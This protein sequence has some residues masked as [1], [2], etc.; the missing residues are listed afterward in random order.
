[1]MRPTR[2][3]A[4]HADVRAEM[5]LDARARA[6]GPHRSGA[7]GTPA[8]RF[9]RN[10]RFA[11]A[12]LLALAGRCTAAGL[13]C[14]STSAALA[15]LGACASGADE[16]CCAAL[17]GWNDA[18]CFCPGVESA[19]SQ[20]ETYAAQADALAAACSVAKAD[21]ATHATCASLSA[22]D[23]PADEMPTR[24]LPEPA[25]W[26]YVVLDASDPAAP[27][28]RLVWSAA[29]DGG[30][31]AA[32][33]AFFEVTHCT[34]GYPPSEAACAQS[35]TTRTVQVD[36]GDAASDADASSYA[37]SLDVPQTPSAPVTAFVSLTAVAGGGEKSAPLGPFTETANYGPSAEDP[38]RDNAARVFI[39]PD[40][41]GTPLSAD[42]SACG[43]YWAPCA[44][45]AVALAAAAASG[46]TFTEAAPAEL[47]FLPGEHARA[48]NCGAELGA[49]MPVRV[50]GLVGSR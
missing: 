20:S 11:L 16:A 31:D 32:P 39:A 46:A 5:R 8:P 45:L 44:D 50:S 2:R 28:F 14:A 47:V 23:E 18:G 13:D 36:A 10:L 33:T 19:V 48:G 49:A 7:T 34:P 1:M 26:A 9:S 37:Y 22:G 43:A 15:T 6:R 21:L 27:R 3:D 24:A 40:A 29:I 41:S 42:S 30:V 12:A 35:M 4:D 25:H 17:E 38:A